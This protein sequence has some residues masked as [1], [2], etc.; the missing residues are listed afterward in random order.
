MQKR[1]FRKDLSKHEK[2]NDK[3]H[4]HDAMSTV[5]SLKKQ[6][7]FNLSKTHLDT[8]GQP[9]VLKFKMSLFTE[10]K[11]HEREFLSDPFYTHPE[12]YKLTIC[13]DA[14][15]NN[16]YNGTHVSVWVYLMKGEYDGQLEFPFKG[17]I[18]IELLNQLDD[19]NHHSKSFTHDGTLDTSERVMYSDKSSTAQGIPDFIPYKDLSYNVIKNCQYL[20][21][22]CLVFRVSVNVPSYKPWLHCP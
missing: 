5:L 12:G 18:T 14:N 11:E 10:K 16:K 8:Q 3:A 6:C 19:N 7:R 21:D 13:V 22:D 17:T 4:F 15:G 9:V 1:P 2:N 20:K